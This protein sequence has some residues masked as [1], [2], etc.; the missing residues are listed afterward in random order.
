MNWFVKEPESLMK[1]AGM[2]TAKKNRILLHHPALLLGGRVV[3]C[4]GDFLFALTPANH[5]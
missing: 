1:R 4:A 2:S 3:V 5:K